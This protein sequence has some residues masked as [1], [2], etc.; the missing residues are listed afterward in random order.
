MNLLFMLAGAYQLASWF[1]ALL[2]RLEKGDR[3]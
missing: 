2:E 3:T 1:M